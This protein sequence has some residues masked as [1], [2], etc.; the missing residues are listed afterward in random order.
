MQKNMGRHDLPIMHSFYIL[1]TKNVQQLDIGFQ[2]FILIYS[3][4]PVIYFQ[5]VSV[6]LF[7]LYAGTLLLL[8]YKYTLWAL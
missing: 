4:S 7:V 5:N 3:K 8:E 6:S 1:H 2:I